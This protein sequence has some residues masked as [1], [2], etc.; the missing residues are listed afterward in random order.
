MPSLND[1][2]SALKAEKDGKRDPA[3]TAIMDGATEALRRS[4][5]TDRAVAVGVT[6]PLFARPDLNGDTVRLSSL[7]RGGPVVLSFFR[8]RW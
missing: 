3:A 5:A 2:L 1:R 7:L 4:G 6:A 8:G